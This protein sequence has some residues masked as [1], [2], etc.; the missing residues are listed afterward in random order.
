MTA[1]DPTSTR[2]L[3]E[4]RRDDTTRSR[5]TR[6]QINAARRAA[7]P[8]RQEVFGNF[9]EHLG[10]A[11]YETVWAQALVNPNLEKVEE[12]DSKPQRWDVAGG[13]AW[14]EEGY[15]SPRSVRLPAGGVLSQRIQV[16]ICIARFMPTPRAGDAAPCDTTA[17]RG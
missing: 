9:V 17:D 11:V 16:G 2:A 15:L 1:P 7:A 5:V 4:Y 14:L 6:V 12:R 8:V 3:F 10:G 13:A